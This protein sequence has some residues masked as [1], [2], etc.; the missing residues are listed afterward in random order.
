MV[1][2]A[3]PFLLTF[4]PLSLLG[5]WVVR[6]CCVSQIAA[7]REHDGTGSV[8]RHWLTSIPLLWLL[9]ASFWF[10]ANWRLDHLLLLV[11]V[12]LVIIIT[13]NRHFFR[14]NHFY[15]IKML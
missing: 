6:Y 1:F 14:H 10:Y 2:S 9:G 4:L 3:L 8:A 12:I 11:T 13:S 7:P 15:D 5:F